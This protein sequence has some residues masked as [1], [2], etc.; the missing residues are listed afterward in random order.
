M[1]ELSG[2]EDLLY[3]PQCVLSEFEIPPLLHLRIEIFVP[4]TQNFGLNHLEYVYPRVHVT[5][6]KVSIGLANSA[7]IM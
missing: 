5:D 2:P 4:K 1:G 7:T 6:K 3:F